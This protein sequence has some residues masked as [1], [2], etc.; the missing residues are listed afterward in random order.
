[1]D[2]P[3]FTSLGADCGGMSALP[4][5]LAVVTG[6]LVPELSDDGRRLAAA[7]TDRGL[8][9]EPVRWDDPSVD[10]AA[11]DAVLF[12]SCWDYPDDLDRFRRLL[13]EVEAADCL[14][15]NPMAVIRWNLHKSY[16]LDLANA[17]VEVPQTV[18]VERGS[19]HSLEDILSEN[20]W[21]EAVVKP[22]I[23]AMSSNVRRISFDDAADHQAHF[24]ELVDVQD[25]LV[26]AFVPEIIHGERSIVFFGGKFS[27]TWNSLPEPDDVTSFDGIDPD[28]APRRVVREQA[29]TVVQA[30]LDEFA[31]APSELPYA[32]V[33]YVTRD[34]TLILLELELIE[35]FLGLDRGTDT[36]SMFCDA[37]EAYFRNQ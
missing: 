10:W 12:R 7:L 35:P 23:G 16:L 32:R 34:D 13:D 1:M 18:V 27:H 4:S 14:V 9:N 20:G 28:Y 24:D 2:N 29:Q 26:Q 25:V 22:A 3:W 31:I 21:Q 11:Y 36:V 8:E 37:L 15:A 6:A 5:Q 19:D 33:D 17:G 30:V